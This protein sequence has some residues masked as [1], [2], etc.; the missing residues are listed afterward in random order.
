[1]PE[2]KVPQDR[3]PKKATKNEDVVEPF[4][5]TH[6]GKEYTLQSA[7]ILSVGFARKIRHLD[8]SSQFFEILEALADDDALAA[9]DG[10]HRAEFEQFTSDFYAHSKVHQGESSPSSN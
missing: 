3:K 10:M 4:T 7:D 6:D 5:F 8:Q 1:M 2:S 9:I